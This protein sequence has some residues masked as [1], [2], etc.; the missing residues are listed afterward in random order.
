MNPAP[1]PDALDFLLTR[2]SRLAKFMTGP[3]PSREEIA[4]MLRAA[5]RTP[6]HGK[7]EPWRFLVLSEAAQR[8]LGALTRRLGE[9]KGLDPE[10][11]DRD[12]EA[13]EGTPAAVAV[14]SSPK[15]ESKIPLI[16]QQLSAG[17]AALA[18]LNAALA[19]G[20]GANWLS[21][22]QAHDRDFLSEGLGL[23]EHEFVAGYIHMGT[24]TRP[25]NERPRPDLDAIVEWVEA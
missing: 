14:V 25:A 21:G 6:D 10:K 2:R 8:R 12:A 24:Y 11:I 3:G 15:P 19:S 9:T 16:E 23:A 20:W 17:G 7:M 13:F 4:V 1:R 18:L 5:S 22:W